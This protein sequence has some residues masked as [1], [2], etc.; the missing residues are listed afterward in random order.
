MERYW[1]FCWSTWY[2]SGG[3]HD[4]K[5]DHA[6]FQHAVNA[7]NMYL[8]EEYDGHA[9]VLDSQTGLVIYFADKDGA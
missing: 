2:P 9:E 6:V 4:F 3:I 8:A 5:S 1:V 7:A